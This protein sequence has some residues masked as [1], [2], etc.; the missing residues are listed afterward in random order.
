MSQA[1]IFC[2][3]KCLAACRSQS[4]L[5]NIGG[6]MVFYGG[7][8]WLVPLGGRING[9]CPS[10]PPCCNLKIGGC[11]LTSTICL[12]YIHSYFSLFTT[13]T[14]P[15]CKLT[16]LTETSNNGQ[17]IKDWQTVYLSI[18]EFC[19][20]D[21]SL[22]FVLYSEQFF[23]LIRMLLLPNQNLVSYWRLPLHNG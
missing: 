7:K 20:T 6:S 18:L 10:P 16:F 9:A 19:L 22:L 23:F 17:L 5:S 12:S 2:D 8:G 21:T 14:S 13:S 11:S 15:K 4:K 1:F 3:Y